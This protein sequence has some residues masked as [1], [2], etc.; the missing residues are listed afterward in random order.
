LYRLLRHS[1][2]FASAV[3]EVLEEKLLREISPE[4]LTLSQFNLLKLIALNGQHQVGELAEFLGVSP[5]AASKAIDKL[6]RLGLVVRSPSKE[7]RRVTLLSAST[8]GR[9]LVAS[10]ED[11][12]ADRL[13]PVLS[14]FRP[15][16]IDEMSSL[17]ERFSMRLYEVE[18]SSSGLCLRCAAYV[19]DHCP[20]AHYHDN[21]PYQKMRDKH[22]AE[23]PAKESL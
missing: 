18:E 10:F 21:C 1:H 3:R 16:E 15:E 7:D 19:E 22:A 6:E 20:V 23:P 12:T 8:D 9:R 5:P 17:L 14:K 2:I 11:L 4:R 13:A